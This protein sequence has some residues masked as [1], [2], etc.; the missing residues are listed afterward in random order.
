MLARCAG[1]KQPQACGRRQ[2]AAPVPQRLEFSRFWGVGLRVSCT[3]AKVLLAQ[4]LLL[5]LF[6]DAHDHH[7]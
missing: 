2:R 5:L 1:P 7:Q 4:M 3:P 6:D